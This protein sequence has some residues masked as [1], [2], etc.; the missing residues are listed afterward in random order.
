VAYDL[1]TAVAAGKLTDV[2]AIAAELRSLLR[3]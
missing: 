1:T 3:G 2:A